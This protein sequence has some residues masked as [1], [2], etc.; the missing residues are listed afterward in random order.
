M[1]IALLM[2][3]CVRAFAALLAP[4]SARVEA[5]RPSLAEPRAPAC[6]LAWAEPFVPEVLPARMFALPLAE[7]AACAAAEWV[8]FNPAVA[9][10]RAASEPIALEDTFPAVC[11]VWFT[12]PRTWCLAAETRERACVVKSPAAPT[13][14]LRAPVVSMAPVAV[15]SPPT[16]LPA[17]EPFAVASPFSAWVATEPFAGLAVCVAW[18]A[19]AATFEAA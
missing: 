15:D 17:V 4:P 13:A 16:A 10:S 5:E 2:D 19:P 7:P 3:Q 6:P 14:V 9:A 1:A 8:N 12:V 18:A 11:L